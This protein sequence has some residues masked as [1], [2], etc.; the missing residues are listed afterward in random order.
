MS[1]AD[2]RESIERY[3][4]SWG[5]KGLVVDDLKHVWKG[6]E[7]PMAGLLQAWSEEEHVS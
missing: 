6:R 7:G 1:E 2:F 3:W 5:S 4:R